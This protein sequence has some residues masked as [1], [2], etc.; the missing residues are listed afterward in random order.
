MNLHIFKSSTRRS[1]DYAGVLECDNRSSYFYLYALSNP[2]GSKVVGAIQLPNHSS[3]IVE[4]YY[5]VRWNLVEDIVGVFYRDE[6]LAAFNVNE[7]SK[8]KGVY[9]A[10]VG[11]ELKASKASWQ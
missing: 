2:G 3:T 11:I 10:L 5:D 6:P 1:A 9:P 8:L 7:Y 4:D